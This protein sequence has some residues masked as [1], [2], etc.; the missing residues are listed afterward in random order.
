M[1][2]LP[3]DETQTRLVKKGGSLE[4]VLPSLN[5]RA[6]RGPR[7]HPAGTNPDEPEPT[8]AARPSTA[9]ALQDR[10]GR[11]ATSTSNS[12]MHWAKS[13]PAETAPAAAHQQSQHPL[14]QPW[15]VDGVTVRLTKL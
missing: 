11:G 9:A 4:L 13:R 1:G 6:N 2:R 15:A 10:Q 8:S 5:P 14:R 12:L 7:F 3:D